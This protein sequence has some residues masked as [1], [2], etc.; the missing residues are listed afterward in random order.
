MV[1]SGFPNFEHQGFSGLVAPARTPP[2]I[3]RLLNQHLND[4]I[5]QPSFYNRFAS[6]GMRPPEKNRPQD[7]ADYLRDQV[8]RHGAIAKLIKK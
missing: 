2:E 4:I 3:I 7:F 5:R 1:E 6:N 8:A